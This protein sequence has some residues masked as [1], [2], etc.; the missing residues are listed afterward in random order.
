MF[1]ISYF[2]AT[3]STYV[4]KFRD[5]RV[6]R[7][8][9]GLAFFYNTYRSSLV[10]VP[11][12]GVEAPFMFSEVSADFQDV[13]VQGQATVRVADPKLI[14][15]LMNFSVSPRGGY[16]TDSPTR[17]PMRVVNAVQ[18]RLR[19]VLQKMTLR[20]LLRSSE[21]VRE[22][23][24]AALREPDALPSLGL[25]L[26]SLAI[27]AIRPSPETG[28][29]LEAPVRESLLKEADDATY[30]RR[31]SAIEQ[32][33]AIRENE[34]ATERAVLEK[35][36]QIDD[37]EMGGRIA[38]EERNKALTGLRAQNARTEAE[39]KAFAM[40][41][42]M[43]SIAG[44]DPRVLQALTVGQADPNAL[45]AAAF[46]G[47]AENAERIGELNISPDLLQ[48]LARRPVREE[49]RPAARGDKGR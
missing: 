2:K 33:R 26:V 20:E 3:P 12:E 6:V 4:L 41:E 43:K 15:G 23:V 39:A 37:Q 46:Q 24:D 27:L 42:L 45:I 38:L 14:A 29:A 16:L 31:N 25:E 48:E 35:R 1:G 22:K 49:P 28:R 21:A 10:A 9:A 47:L 30:A 8:G 40:A 13:T 36:Q 32:E 7:E 17:L 34:L 19:S 11:L 5:G 44:V 18:V